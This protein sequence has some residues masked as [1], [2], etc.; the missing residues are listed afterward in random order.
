[1]RND[2][3]SDNRVS[4]NRVSDRPADGAYLHPPSARPR[5]SHQTMQSPSCALWATRRQH[6]RSGRAHLRVSIALPNRRGTTAWWSGQQSMWPT[7]FQWGTTRSATP[8][9]RGLPVRLLAGCAVCCAGWVSKWLATRRK[10]AKG[11]SIGSL[12]EIGRARLYCVVR[13]AE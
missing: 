12:C 10:E 11:K 8:D 5:P 4:D 9:P 1:M 7:H 13:L 3:V 6:G 2:R